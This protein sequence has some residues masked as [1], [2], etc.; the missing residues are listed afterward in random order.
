MI[1]VSV[2]TPIYRNESYLARCFD[3]L[4]KQTLDNIEFIWIDNGSS[5]ESREIIAKYSSSRPHIKV[6]RL[7]EN[8]GY[9]GAIN[10]GLELATGEYI[11]FCDSDDWLDNDY[12]EKLY[13]EA[14][15]KQADIVYSCYKEE[16]SDKSKRHDHLV[17]KKDIS[18]ETQK[19]HALKNGAIW[20]KIFRREML[21]NN[22]ILFP[23]FN[24]SIATDNAFLIPAILSSEKI[25]LVSYPYY[26]YFQNPNSVMHRKTDINLRIDKLKEVISNILTYVINKNISYQTK[27]EFIAFLD[28]SL[29]LSKV[30]QKD[31][32]YSFFNNIL[33][34]D[35]DFQD[36]LAQ[37]RRANKP[38]FFQKIFSIQNRYNKRIL[39]I[40]GIKIKIKQKQKLMEAI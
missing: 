8:I 27:Y 38:T 28:R 5:D 33:K 19:I 31:E 13:T 26:H 3:S 10:K 21:V 7:K 35:R 1:N 4:V 25:V 23:S 29:E 37:F 20:D 6:V 16:F 39:W 9:C 30:I 15:E 18:N 34:D 36:L 40:L 32:D 22:N 24:H 2:I 14:K 17:E 12:F 11:G